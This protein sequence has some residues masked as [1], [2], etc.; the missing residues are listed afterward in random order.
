MGIH[1]ENLP[2]RQVGKT[3]IEAGSM[4]NDLGRPLLEGD[5][6]A[7]C[8]IISHRIHKTL[9]CEDGLACTRASYQQARAIER[10]A[11]LAQDIEP[12]NAGGSLGLLGLCARRPFSVGFFFNFDTPS[13]LSASLDHRTSGQTS[14]YLIILYTQTEYLTIKKKILVKGSAR[15]AEGTVRPSCG[16]LKWIE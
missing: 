7:R 5:E 2:F 10:K 4:C 16:E 12:F 11:A 3:P 6:D 1:K 9:Q 14:G 13:R 8:T 15:R